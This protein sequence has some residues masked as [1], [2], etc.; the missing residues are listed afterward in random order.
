MRQDF[1]AKVYLSGL[2]S[3]LTGPAQD[4]LDARE[5]RHPQTVNRSV[6]FK[7]LKNEALDLLLGNLETGP[8]LKRLTALFLTNPSLERKG[9]K[10]LRTKSSAR[11]LLDFHK[12]QKKYCF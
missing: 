1:H 12:R 8:L 4:R 2:E 6:S 3:I 5:V 11:L 10:P 7:A 9:R